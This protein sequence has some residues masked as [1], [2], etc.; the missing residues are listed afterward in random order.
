MTQSLT[1]LT[2]FDGTIHA[3]FSRSHVEVRWT[4][5]REMTFAAFAA[6]LREP[7]V[8]QKTGSCYTPAIFTGSA[9]RMDQAEQID[10]AVLDSDCGHTREEIEAALQRQGWSGVIHSTFNHLNDQTAIAAA[11]VEKWLADHPGRTVAE[12]LT[13]KKGYLPRVVA[14]A[15]IVN[16]VRDGSARNL[17]VRHQP[18][19]KYRVILPL[20]APWRAGDYPSQQAANARWRERVGAL[21]HALGLHHDQSC[22]DTSRLF[23]L[24]RKSTAEAVFEFS[25]LS[26]QPCPIFALA[27]AVAPPDGLFSPSAPAPRQPPVLQTVTPAHKVAT[28]PDGEVV[29]LTVWAAQ[30][31]SR[32]QVVDMLKARLPGIFSARRS[33]VK[34]HIIC[35]N[36]ASHITGGE[37][38]TGTYCVNAEDVPQSG[39]TS[40]TSGFVIHCMHS[41]CSGHDRLDHLGALIESGKITVDDLA[42][43]DFLLPLPPVDISGIMNKRARVRADVPA[44]SGRTS[45]IAPALY[46]AL[47]GVMRDMHDYI[48]ATAVKAQPALALASVLTFFGAAIGRKAELDSM[49]V[50]AN[51]YALAVA[52]SGAGKERLLSAP[53]KVALHAGLYNLIGVEEVA[54]DTGIINA[55][56]AQPNQVMLLDEVSFLFGSTNNKHAGVHIVNV[57]STLLKLY[58][59]SGTRFKGKSYADVE[60]IKSVDQPCVS[61]LGCSTPAGLFSA[62]SSKDVHNGLLSRFVLFD[63]GDHD[64]LGSTPERRDPPQAVIDWLRAWESRPLNQNPMERIDGELVIRPLMIPMTDEA[65]AIS[66]DF[67]VEMHAKKIEARERGTDALYVRARENALKFA[68]VAACSQPAI[69][70][71][72]GKPVIDETALVVTG[73]TM[74]WAC[75][76]SRVTITA[77]ETGARDEIVDTQFQQ[78]VREVRNAI[79]KAGPKGLTMRELAKDVVGR[80]PQREMQDVLQNLTSSETIF[81]VAIKTPGRPRMALVHRDYAET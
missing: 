25:A 12:Y 64:P 48:V 28:S 35:P 57:T 2:G 53:K 5:R 66:R 37:E 51:I 36:S 40:I 15:E 42:N 54:S 34:H 58:S 72:D 73:E 33:G 32:F 45:N 39:L 81:S 43:E 77:M 68:L 78:R 80:L 30:L 22:V 46:A 8:G 55:V 14:G 10:M 74:R 59:S 70:D 62:L 16:E 23:Y 13:E 29:D 7:P 31:A 76:L 24:P 60:K 38:G 65:V 17:I 41:G 50:R 4:D 26:G 75:E 1:D 61:V 18:C 11:P 6:L 71:A 67:E 27:D 69:Y 63:A 9:R 44:S 52:H 21:A 56:I 47:P 3:T 49:G 20:E 19:P 79:R